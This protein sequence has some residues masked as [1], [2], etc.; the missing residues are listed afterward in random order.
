MALVLLSEESSYGYEL[1]KRLEEFALEVIN[2]W[3][4]Y[5][6]LR[7][8]E[9]EGLCASELEITEL[10]AIE[11]GRARRRYSITDAGESY[12]AAYSAI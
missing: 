3:T 4:L 12:L 6:T 5:S 10:E 11:G 8:M 9:T 1:M 7:Q 2:P